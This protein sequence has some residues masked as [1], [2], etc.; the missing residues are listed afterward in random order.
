MKTNAS[1]PLSLRFSPQVRK[2][3]KR[4]SEDTGLIQAQVFDMLMRAACA[5]I[6]ENNYKFQIP[7]HFSLEEK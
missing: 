1:K 6:E 3:V 2:S 4:I 7:L 5:A